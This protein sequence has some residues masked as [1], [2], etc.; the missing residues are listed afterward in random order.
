MRA[1]F[2]RAKVGRGDVFYVNL[3]PVI[4]SEQ[5][6][7]RPVLILQ[8]DIGN[9]HSPTVIVAAISSR[10]GK[11][12]LPVHVELDGEKYGLDKNSIVLLEQIRTIDK[13]RLH[14]WVTRLDGAVMCRVNQAIVVSLGLSETRDVT[15]TG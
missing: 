12:R 15:A 6:G 2:R 7:V 14:G 9:R 5:G 13:E 11:G 4:G 1:M 10:T 8:N 3:D